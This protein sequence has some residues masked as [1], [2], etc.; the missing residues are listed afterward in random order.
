MTLMVNDTP[1][2]SPLKNQAPTLIDRFI[3]RIQDQVKQVTEYGFRAAGQGDTLAHRGTDPLQ[4]VAEVTGYGYE[5]AR[6]PLGVVGRGPGISSVLPE[7]VFQQPVGVKADPW[8]RLDSATRSAVRVAQALEDHIG[9]PVTLHDEWD[10]S[11]YHFEVTRH[12]GL[13]RAWVIPM[14][15]YNTTITLAGMALARFVLDDGWCA[16]LV[17]AE[18]GHEAVAI[19]RK[20]FL[21][22]QCPNL[23]VPLEVKPRLM[24]VLENYLALR[25]RHGVPLGVYMSSPL[26]VNFQVMLR[27]LWN[28]VPEGSTKDQAPM[29]VEVWQKDP[30]TGEWRQELGETE[31]PE[32]GEPEI[33][34]GDG[35][36]A[37]PGEG[38][39][40]QSASGTGDTPPTGE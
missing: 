5:A 20:A 25:D 34:H 24:Q 4:H 33:T 16:Y 11:G 32:G 30:E 17:Q 19:V 7:V 23:R 22:E 12:A 39:G 40:A 28:F 2:L 27:T 38:S 10:K 6:V 31:T 35:A 18:S 3:Q 29:L 37:T 8:D 26:A 9:G 36:G 15:L 13:T 21:E 14:S 1:G